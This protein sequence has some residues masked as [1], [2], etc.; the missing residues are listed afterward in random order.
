MPSRSRRRL[1]CDYGAPVS[2]LRAASSMRRPHPVWGM[3][4]RLAWGILRGTSAC[5][6]G[7]SVAD[8]DQPKR[9]IVPIPDVTPPGLT[10]YDA[11]DPDTRFPP[12]VALRPPEGAPN[13]LIV[14]LDDVGYGASSA[15]GG[16]CRTPTFERLAG[17]GLRYTRFHTTAL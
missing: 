1:S 12:I 9:E 3:P 17:Q 4:G 10:T 2:L 13:V 16:P 6:R 15:F 8:H 11:K 7:D 14:L 5:S